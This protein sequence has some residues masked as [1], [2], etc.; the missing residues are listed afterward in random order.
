MD[1]V[2]L[3]F[4]TAYVLRMMMTSRIAAINPWLKRAPSYIRYVGTLLSGHDCWATFFAISVS[5]AHPAVNASQP[6]LMPTH[7]ITVFSSIHIGIGCGLLAA[8]CHRANDSHSSDVIAITRHPMV[9]TVSHPIYGNLLRV[10]AP[11]N[12]HAHLQPSRKLSPWALIWPFPF[13]RG[14]AK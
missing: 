3:P 13:S 6:C 4:G 12:P 14:H 7:P 2:V 5:K 8:L 10:H 1:D 9:G 11:Q